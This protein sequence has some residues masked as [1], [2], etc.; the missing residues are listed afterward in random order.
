MCIA[1]SLIY[2]LTD[3]YMTSFSP[4]IYRAVKRHCCHKMSLLITFAIFV[5]FSK[6]AKAIVKQGQIWGHCWCDELWI[7]WMLRR[8]FW[9]GSKLWFFECFACSRGKFPHD[10]QLLVEIYCELWNTQIKSI[11]VIPK[12][13]ELVNDV[14][15]G[16]QIVYWGQK[17]KNENSAFAYWSKS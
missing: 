12:L 6:N 15:C 14:G 1:N 8:L 3:Y 17:G 13:R 16:R 2:R 5:F 9:F 4:Y 11:K 7:L 10:L